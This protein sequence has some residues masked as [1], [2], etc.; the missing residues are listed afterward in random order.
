MRREVPSLTQASRQRESHLRGLP[1]TSLLQSKQWQLSEIS[2]GLALG[3][4]KRGV[5]EGQLKRF[6]SVR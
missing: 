1:P 3:R 6:L 2:D 4:S 5:S